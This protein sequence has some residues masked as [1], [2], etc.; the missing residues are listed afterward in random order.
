MPGRDRRH[1][2]A[3]AWPEVQA[4]I[5]WLDLEG[6]QARTQYAYERATAPL[7]RSHLGK[8]LADFTA[9]DI[10]AE[11]HRIPPRSRY[12][13]RSIYN[14][15][16]EWAEFHDRIGRSPMGKVARMKAGHRRPKDIFAPEEVAALVALPVPDGPLFQ[17]LFGTG[18]RR[19]E[20]RR[21]R[22]DHID[23][24]RMRLT[25]YNGK[26][27]K[28]AIVP[29]GVAVAAAVADLD[30]LER[31]EPHEHLWYLR[32]YPVGDPRRRRDPIGDTTWD[33]WYRNKIRDADVRMLNPHQTRHT[34]HWLLRAEGLDL[35][36]RQTLMRHERPETTV[37]QY[38]RVDIEEIAAKVAGF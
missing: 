19:A 9:D 16:F 26:G 13:S 21:L 4:W 36:H 12:I 32:R 7:L 11:L 35:E 37:R 6:K 15:L 14:Q 28:D 18:L 31:V 29:F 30:L 17:I 25:V 33:T 3:A 34:Y 27:G 23:V 22:R 1:E 38:G 5:A 24:P 20:A 2:Q 8:R 10:N